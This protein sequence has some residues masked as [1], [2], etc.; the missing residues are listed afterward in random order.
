MLITAA[1]AALGGVAA[2]FTISNDVLGRDE[3]DHPEG[4]YCRH[5]AM[6]G[7]PLVEQADTKEGP[8]AEPVPAAGRG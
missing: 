5:C 6:A 7:T 4:E 2:W 8:V 1:A 3:H